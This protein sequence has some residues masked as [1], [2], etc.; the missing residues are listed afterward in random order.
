MNHSTDIRHIAVIAGGASRRMGRDKASIVTGDGTTWL[1]RIV[2]R[3][4]ETGVPVVVIG[5]NR[6]EGWALD[7]VR[8]IADDEPGL[9]PIGGIRTALRQ[10]GTGVLAVACDQ[11]LLTTGALL[12]LLE[13]RADRADGVL[14]TRAGVVE[15]LFSIYE[16]SA[17]AT[18]D[19][20]LASGERA[21]KAA[22][23]SGRFRRV[24]LPTEFAPALLNVNTP[25]ELAELER[26][27]ADGS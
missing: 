18:I 7:A 17:L 24:E 23:R 10:V 6:P 14:V 25:E 5:R 12:W 16:Q 2:R 9:G 21:L 11:P 20:V 15:P 27:S 26:R 1:D 3:A 13:Q 19:A 8:F 4:L 22:I